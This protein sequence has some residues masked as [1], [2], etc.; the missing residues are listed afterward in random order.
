VIVCSIREGASEAGEKPAQPAS[1]SRSGA[2]NERPRRRRG[3]HKRRGRCREHASSV[4]K[5]KSAKHSRP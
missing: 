2:A 4:L 5:R 1:T 3:Q